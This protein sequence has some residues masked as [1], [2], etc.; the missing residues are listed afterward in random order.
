M[1]AKKID[2]WFL[3]ENLLRRRHAFRE[4]QEF[5]K[6]TSITLSIT[7]YRLLCKTSCWNN[8]ANALVAL[9]AIVAV[10]GGL[11]SISIHKIEE[12]GL[13]AY[14]CLLRKG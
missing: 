7:E 10:G 9:V 8:M 12:G 6:L 13:W 14:A 3:L 2:C 11:V 4:L 1:K 5:T